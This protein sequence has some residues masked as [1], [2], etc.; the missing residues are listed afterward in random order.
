MRWYDLRVNLE[1]ETYGPVDLIFI[2]DTTERFTNELIA[3]SK[4]KK[5]HLQLKFIHKDRRIYYK[6]KEW[7]L[8][9]T[10]NHDMKPYLSSVD[11]HYIDVSW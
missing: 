7:F 11:E 9:T 3:A 6:I 2:S 4:E 8:S 10:L 5:N 1:N